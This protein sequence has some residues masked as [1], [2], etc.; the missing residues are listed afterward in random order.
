MMARVMEMERARSGT[1]V[2]V[3]SRRSVGACGRGSRLW[4]SEEARLSWFWKRALFS[5]MVVQTGFE[6]IAVSRFTALW[7]CSG[8]VRVCQE[9]VY[10]YMI[11]R[12]MEVIFSSPRLEMNREFKQYVCLA[13]YLFLT[14]KQT[15]SDSYSPALFTAP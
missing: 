10:E 2:S 4:G 9:V 5:A 14:V 1:R 3:L 13:V 12:G 11:A 8:P 7:G 15:E 6:D